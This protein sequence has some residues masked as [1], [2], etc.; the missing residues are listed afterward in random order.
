MAST[1]SFRT[2][3]QHPVPQNIMSV[4][5]KLIGELT[6]KQF[7]YVVAG[8]IL[9]AI[10][11]KSGIY[12][13]WRWLLIFTFI[14]VSVGMAFVPVQD[15]GLDIWLKSFV[16]ALFSPVLMIWKKDLM[17]PEFF[18][19]L[20]AIIP[21]AQEKN[22]P[23]IKAMQKDELIKTLDTFVDYDEDPLEE[24]R[25][26][27]IR[28]LQ[29][30]LDVKE[31]EEV[32]KITNIEEKDK[33][34][35]QQKHTEEAMLEPLIKNDSQ[36]ITYETYVP[37]SSVDRVFVKEAVPDYRL[38]LKQAEK[39]ENDETLTKRVE[40]HEKKENQVEIPIKK[41]VV[42]SEPKKT[43]IPK[44]SLEDFPPNIIHGIVYNNTHNLLE[45]AL[46]LIKDETG[47]PKRA[48]KSNALGRFAVTTPMENGIYNLEVRKDDLK[49]DTIKIELTGEKIAPIEITAI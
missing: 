35:D 22:P 28:N 5:F 10:A 41:K 3:K 4:E 19:T 48:V 13:I 7:G 16:R 40:K 36:K 11:Y 21:V 25:R 31:P 24:P 26:A 20:E 8:I 1:D 39:P 32:N 37:Q 30:A 29:F 46:V 23:E 17:R 34:S 49:F 9:A 45:G 18:N 6:I 33:N 42:I 44:A 2:S 38:D 27:F 14:G 47:E 12:F 43:P 15:R